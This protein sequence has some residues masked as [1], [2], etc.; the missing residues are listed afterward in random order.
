[1][2]LLRLLIA[3]GA[4]Q[5]AK[6]SIC[7]QTPTPPSHKENYYEEKNDTRAEPRAQ[8]RSE[9]RSEG[10]QTT[11]QAINPCGTYLA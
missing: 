4:E 10:Y 8:N 2:I 6:W 7:Q 11:T 1:M 9:W 3:P 5:R